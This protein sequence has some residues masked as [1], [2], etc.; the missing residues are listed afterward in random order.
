MIS[1]SS[2]ESITSLSISRLVKASRRSFAGFQNLPHLLHRFVDD[3]LHFFI[4]FAG[5]LLAMNAGACDFAVGGQKRRAVAFAIVHPAQVAHAVVHD[6]GRAMSL[7]RS[8]SFW[9]P[10]EMS[11]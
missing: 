2:S 1:F 7:A 6:H 3:A 11:L 9:A 5:R 10:V 8:R 4:D